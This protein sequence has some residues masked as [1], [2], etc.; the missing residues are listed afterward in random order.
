[1]IADGSDIFSCNL[2]GWGSNEYGQLTAN[3]IDNNETSLISRD[4]IP[5]PTLLASHGSSD[6]MNSL[7]STLPKDPSTYQGSSVWLSAGGK[8]SALLQ[9][10]RIL[11]VWGDCNPFL[12]YKMRDG[13]KYSDAAESSEVQN[14]TSSYIAN[15]EGVSISHN[16]LLILLM[17]GTVIEMKIDNAEWNLKYYSERPAF[18]TTYPSPDGSVTLRNDPIGIFSFDTNIFRQT[19]ADKEAA[20]KILKLSAGL[21]HSATITACGKLFCWGNNKHGQCANPL[22]SS[23]KIANKYWTH[24]D[25]LSFIDIACGARHTV[26]MD[27]EGKLWSWGDNQ[28]GALGRRLPASTSKFDWTP[29][30]VENLDPN[31]RWQRVSIP[32]KCT[33]NSDI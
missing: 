10:N 33:H 30:L 28:F 18:V 19:L 23:E 15:V 27:E 24:P 8:L 17:C 29:Q 1:M 12:R 20:F 6:D 9:K 5:Q 14:G 3:G 13:L 2:I 22:N 32:C 4:I 31:I 26:A 25:N 7:H 21:H 16:H 11:K